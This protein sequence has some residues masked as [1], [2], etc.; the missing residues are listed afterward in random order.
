MLKRV[1]TQISAQLKNSRKIEVTRSDGE[2]EV[3]PEPEKWKGEYQ[4]D[5]GQLGR[6]DVEDE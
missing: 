3:K 1:E 4:K 6:E 5:L 2:E